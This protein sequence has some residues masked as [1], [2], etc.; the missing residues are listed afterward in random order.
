MSVTAT[1][2]PVSESKSLKRKREEELE[3]LEVDLDAAE[4]PSKKALRKAKRG[5]STKSSIDPD[6]ESRQDTTDDF[7]AFTDE[8]PTAK[9]KAE[10]DPISNRARSGFGIWI[11]NLS[12]TTTRDDL[13]NFIT[14]DTEHSITKDQVTRLN[15]PHGPMKQGKPQNKG[16]A[17]IDFV[18]ADTLGRAIEL[19]E[20]LLGGRRVLIK[21]AKSF[22]GRP[23]SKEEV[24]SGKPPSRRIFVGNLSFDTTGEALEEHFGVCGSITKTQVATFEDSGK[25]KGYA[26]VEFE[27]L[28]SAQAAMRGWVEQDSSGGVRLSKKRIWLKKMDGRPLRMEFAEDATTRYNKRYGKDAKK[29]ATSE[30]KPEESEEPITEVNAGQQP[31]TQPRARSESGKKPKRHGY[32]DETVKRLT[33]AITESHGK[34]V[35][36]D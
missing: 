10:Q 6:K 3:E 5:K 28:S 16:F 24:A 23:A 12:F 19:S 9:G 26:W 2:K 21:D 4:P 27:Q 35:V 18:D 33:G 31:T 20:K 36:F 29:A 25:C 22:E 32:E 30:G 7:I 14:S 1:A 17:Y 13:M 8:A 11:G 15:L 34:K